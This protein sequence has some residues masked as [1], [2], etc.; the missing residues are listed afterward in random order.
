M[1][2]ILLLLW[3]EV[4]FAAPLQVSVFDL[5]PFGGRD[6]EGRIVGIIPEILAEIEQ[7]TGLSFEKKVVPYKRMYYELET[8]ESDLAIFF[9]ST[10]SETIASSK[11]RIYTLRNIVVGKSSIDLLWYSDLLGYTIS[12]PAGTRYYDK[13]DDD[14]RLKK[15]YVRGFSSAVSQLLADRVDL[16]AG[17]EISISY[18]LHKQKQSPDILGEAFFLSYSSAWVQVSHQSK[19]ITPEIVEKIVAGVKNL[20]NKGVIDAILRKYKGATS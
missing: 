7:E 14:H 12:V 17:P 19:N 9:R 10:K 15:I 11:A 5:P 18:Y 16:V 20:H 1:C 13:F 6:D 8:G 2:S 3:S 4:S